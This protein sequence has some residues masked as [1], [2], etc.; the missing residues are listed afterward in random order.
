MDSTCGVGLTTANVS[1]AAVIKVRVRGL[2]E[3][4]HVQ[5]S[6]ASVW[7]YV[8]PSDRLKR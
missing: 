5:K 1:D 8:Q 4:R 6:E 2:R 7:M 3:E